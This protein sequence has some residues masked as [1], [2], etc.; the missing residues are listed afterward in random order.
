MVAAILSAYQVAPGRREEVIETLRETKTVYDGLGGK[1]QVRQTTAGGEA[2]GRI[3][4]VLSFESPAARATFID[5]LLEQQQ[6][7]PILAALEAANPRATLVTRY[8]S[9]EVNPRPDGDIPPASKV[10]AANSYRIAPGHFADFDAA[11]CGVEVACR[12]R[13]AAYDHL[14]VGERRHELGSP[15]GHRRLR[16][17]PCAVGVPSASTGAQRGWGPARWCGPSSPA[18]WSS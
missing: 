14:A 1:Y 17:L 5:R 18:R 4:T 8:F 7:V 16:Q 6:I 2:S 10:V 9:N 15:G 12:E 13:G 11:L 3:L